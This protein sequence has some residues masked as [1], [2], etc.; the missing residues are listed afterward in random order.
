MNLGKTTLEC[1]DPIGALSSL[2]HERGA[3]ERLRQWDIRHLSALTRTNCNL[4]RR[5]E[6]LRVTIMLKTVLRNY[7]PLAFGTLAR[8]AKRPWSGRYRHQSPIPLFG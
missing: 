5:K 6:K 3:R 4:E 7:R 1:E 2:L 8:S